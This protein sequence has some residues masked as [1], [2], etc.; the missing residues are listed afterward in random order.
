M[1]SQKKVPTDLQTPS[2]YID[3]SNHN[4]FH[5]Y[6]LVLK[7]SIL[8]ANGSLVEWSE[9]TT[10]PRN[11]AKTWPL[12]LLKQ[13][14]RDKGICLKEL[15]QN[16]PKIRKFGLKPQISRGFTSGIDLRLGLGPDGT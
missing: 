13:T 6:I 2:R 15:A 16:D 10:M 14:L 5:Q 3:Y 4:Q 1:F 8:K 12:A 7:I 9:R 11:A